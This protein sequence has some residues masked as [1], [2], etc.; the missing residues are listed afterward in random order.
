MFLQVFQSRSK[1]VGKLG[2]LLL[3]VLSKDGS[4]KYFEI[5]KLFPTPPPP[6]AP[7]SDA[8]ASS[9]KLSFYEYN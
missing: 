1:Y 5:A 3:D 9:F 6:P 4:F 8:F 2:H 7:V